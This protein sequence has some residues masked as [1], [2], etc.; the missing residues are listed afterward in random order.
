MAGEADDC[1]LPAE[2]SLRWRAMAGHG[3]PEAW[4]S[5]RLVK[6]AQL[7]GRPCEQA[8]PG[9][10]SYRLA[11]VPRAVRRTSGGWPGSCGS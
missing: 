8:W 5:Q 1:P 6:K 11:R 2:A 10:P 7:F 3:V 9:S 4:P